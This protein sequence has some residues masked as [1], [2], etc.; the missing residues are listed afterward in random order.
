MKNYNIFQITNHFYTI[1]S[2][3]QILIM[4]KW[5]FVNEKNYMYII[6]KIEEKEKVLRENSH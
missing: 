2:V 3:R 4:S 5:Y 1:K 6:A